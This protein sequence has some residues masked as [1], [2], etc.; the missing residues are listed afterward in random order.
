MYCSAANVGSVD[1]ALE[2]DH[3]ITFP[4]QHK[5]NRFCYGLNV[6]IPLKF[7]LCNP[8]P[9][10][11]GVRRWGLWQVIRLRRRSP[12]V[13]LMPSEKRPKKVLLSLSVPWGYKKKLAVC[14][15]KEGSYQNPTMLAPWSWTSSL[16]NCEQQ[17]SALCKSL[18]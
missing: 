16:Q 7:I 11:D 10:V 2:R 14:N 13:G 3:K 5:V 18:N 12:M 4:S 6:C 15:P 1:T 9:Q 17:I 8:N